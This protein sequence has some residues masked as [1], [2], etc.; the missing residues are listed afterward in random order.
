MLVRQ[1]LGA[2]G[3]Y[4]RA[5]I[6]ERMA[7]GLDVKRRKGGYTG[8]RPPLGTRAVA[9]ELVADPAEAATVQRIAELR[10]EGASYRQIVA[11]LTVEGRTPKGGGAWHSATVRKVYER[12]AGAGSRSS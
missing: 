11:T 7:A 12:T 6:R 3:Q 4:E 9:G 2:I 5:L 8:G 1:V 10:A